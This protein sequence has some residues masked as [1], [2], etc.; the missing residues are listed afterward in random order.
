MKLLHP[1]V[2]VAREAYEHHIHI[3]ALKEWMP[4]NLPKVFPAIL[5]EIERAFDEL[6]PATDG[7]SVFHHRY[8]PTRSFSAPLRG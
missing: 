8:V 3:A 7:A 5:D 6:I 1:K 2:T 4:R